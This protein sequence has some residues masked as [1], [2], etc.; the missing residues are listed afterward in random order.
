[1]AL[2]PERCIPRINKHVRGPPIAWGEPLVAELRHEE[3][4]FTEHQGAGCT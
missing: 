4:T 3:T 1:M 2:V